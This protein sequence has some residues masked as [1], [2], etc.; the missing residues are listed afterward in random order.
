MTD[1]SAKPRHRTPTASLVHKRLYSV[2]EAAMYL[3]RS[4][5][6][7]RRLIWA[8]E[9]PEVRTGR[10]VHVDLHDLDRFIERHKLTAA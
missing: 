8:G 9:L 1:H 2:A 5:W 7:V 6:A 4:E 10:R 3:G